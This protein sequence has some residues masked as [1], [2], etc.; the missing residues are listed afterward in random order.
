MERERGLARAVRAEQR[1]P[2]PSLD[3]Q[4]DAEQRSVAIRIDVVEVADVER[5]CHHAIHTRSTRR[6]DGGRT[7]REQRARP[8]RPVQAFVGA[9]GIVT[10]NVPS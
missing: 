7:D 3:P 10:G 5:R 2:L 4:V 9:M 1:H 8:P 6:R